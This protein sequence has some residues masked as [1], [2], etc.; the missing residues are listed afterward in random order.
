MDAPDASAP[1]DL[2]GR[3]GGATFDPSAEFRWLIGAILVI[4]LGRCPAE[5]VPTSPPP[6]IV[7]QHAGVRTAIPLS[8][9]VFGQAAWGGDGAAA[10]SRVSGWL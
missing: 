10:H 8:T 2:G 4:G 1:R 7:I 9:Y 3:G 6:S 5:A